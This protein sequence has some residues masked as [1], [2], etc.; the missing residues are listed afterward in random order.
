MSFTSFHFLREL[1][2]DGK[3]VANDTEVSNGEDGRVLIFA[4]GDDVFGTLHTGEVLDGTADA[5]GNVERG[6][7]RLAG[8]SDLVTV[9]QPARID[10]GAGRTGRTAE[11]SSK[12]F[13]QVEIVGFAQAAPTTDDD[14]RVF[15]GWSFGR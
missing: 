14:A 6:L 4:D 9:G 1:W 13:H 5:T 15:Q 10:D 2:Q 12:L 3:G 7:Y 11:S 8:L